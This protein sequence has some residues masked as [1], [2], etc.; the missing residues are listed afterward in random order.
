ML[1]TTTAAAADDAC[2][3]KK[4]RGEKVFMFYKTIGVLHIIIVP[5][6]IDFFLFLS[7]LIY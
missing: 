3:I 6:D 1:V 4:M 7:L 5:G 2:Y